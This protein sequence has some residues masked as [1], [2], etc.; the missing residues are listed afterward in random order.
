MKDFDTIHVKCRPGKAVLKTTLIFALSFTIHCIISGWFSQ[1]TDVGV[2][3]NSLLKTRIIYWIIFF[4]MIT[5]LI[6]KKINSKYYVH[7]FERK[8]SKNGKELQYGRVEYTQTFL[9]KCFGIITVKFYNYDCTEKI[10]LRDVSKS[11][12]YYL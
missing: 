11:I 7:C 10:I 8:V 6:I 2:W 3:Q 1:Y 12:L 9:Q 5:I 4:I